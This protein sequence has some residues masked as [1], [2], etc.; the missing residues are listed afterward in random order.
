MAKRHPPRTEE[1]TQRLV[2]ELEIHQIELE[3]QN[4]EL[5]QA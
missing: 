4:A 1:E 2:H 5:R 3:I